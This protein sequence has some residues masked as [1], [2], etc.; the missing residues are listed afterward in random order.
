MTRDVGHSVARTEFKILK[1]SGTALRDAKY[2]F[3]SCT[4]VNLT[5]RRYSIQPKAAEDS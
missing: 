5:L 4:T 3:N 1:S 2:N